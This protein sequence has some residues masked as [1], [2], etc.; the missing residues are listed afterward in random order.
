MVRSVRLVGGRRDHRRHAD[1]VGT[2]VIR[3]PSGGATQET[4]SLNG[5]TIS[6]GSLFVSADNSQTTLLSTITNNGVMALASTGLSA[7]FVVSGNVTLTGSGVLLMGDNINNRIRGGAGSRLINDVTHT[8]AGSGQLGVDAIAITNAGLIAA[9]QVALLEINP[10]ATGMINTGTLRAA[11]NATLQLT[12]SGGGSFTNTGGTIEAQNGSTVRLIDGAVI[13]GGTLTT[14]G[15]GVIT[16]PSGGAGPNA[17]TLNGVTVSSG[18][19]FVGAP[20]SATTLVGTITN[21]GTMTL[22]STGLAA[23]FVLNGDVTLTGSGAVTLSDSAGNRIYGGAGTSLTNAAGHTIRGSGQIGTG[24]NGL[25]NQGVIL[26]DQSVGLAINTSSAIVNS[27]TL[28]AN[29]GSALTLF[30]SVNNSGTILANGGTVNA[31]AGFTGTTGTAR[32]EGAG[33]IVMG[34]AGSVGNLVLNGTG[35]L[36]LGTNNITVSSAYNNANFGTGN[37]FNARAGVTGSGQILA[38]GNVAQAIT[39]ASVTNGS[40]GTATLTIGNVH[41][42][43]TTV[44]YQIANTG[45]TGPALSGAIQTSVNGGNLTDARL[46]GTGVTASNW[47]PVA[48]GGHSGDRSVTFTTASAGALAPLSG[49]VLHIAN[50][51]GNVS[52]QNLNIVLAGGAAAYNLAAGSATPSPVVLANQ[53]VGGTATQALNV[54]NSAP[55]RRLHRR[56]ERELRCK[57]WQRDEQRRL[58]RLAGR[59]REQ[60]FDGCGRQHRDRRGKKRDGDAEL[61]I[62]RQRNERPGSNGRRFADDHRER[63]RVSAGGGSDRHGAA[64]LRHGAGR[65]A[66]LA[67]PRDPQYRNRCGGLRRGSE[68]QL[69]RGG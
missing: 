17:A 54:T 4:A 57:H 9:N 66:G 62:R 12:G 8:I 14:S 56:S 36:A 38:A 28:Q 18:S 43:A 33:S 52:A 19:R 46:S 64:E 11:N 31:N 37:S 3:T 40:T 48:A 21:N 7:D 51:F 45:T 15:T 49:Q 1:T 61:H 69:R 44:S 60:W 55:D 67:E 29:S 25:T 10:N 16:T 47:G 35:T 24:L 58:D 42:G 41:V 13:A 65:S 59:R 53:R 27:G 50:N 6:G 32:I 34:A 63:Q 23:D 2:G 30:D 26:A 5:V 20:N 68:R 22:A 39:G